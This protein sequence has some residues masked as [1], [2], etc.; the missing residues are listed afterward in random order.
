MIKTAIAGAAGY[1]GGELIRLLMNHPDVL[2]T[3][4]QSTSQSGKLVGSVH[5][6]LAPF[7]DLHFSETLQQDYDVLFLCMGHGQSK[8]YLD[9]NP[10]PDQVLIIDLSQDFR[11]TPTYGNRSFVYGLPEV[12]RAKI[13]G[14]KSMANP[15]CFAT[16]IQLALAPLAAQNVLTQ[17]HVTGITG[18]T[19]AGQALSSTSHFPW[20]NNNISAYKTLTHQH[21]TEINGT[22]KSLQ[23]TPFDLHFIPWRG[24]FARGIFVSAVVPCDLAE[25]KIN[26]LFSQYYADEPFTWVSPSMID[27]K[28]VVNT[29]VCAIYPEKIGRM[30]VVHAALDNLLKGASG[31]AVQS[32]NIAIGLSETCGLHLKATAF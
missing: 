22:L 2:I 19:G 23:S 4:L 29:N 11:N 27:M 20:R 21:L 25:S 14:Q 16:A 31:Q 12:N 1:T 5:T 26:D 17:V 8:Q 9:A 15:G 3:E 30:L 24:D 32:M 6:D 28:Q 18:A 7:C 13:V 10:Q